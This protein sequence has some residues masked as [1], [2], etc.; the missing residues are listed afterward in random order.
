MLKFIVTGQEAVNFI[1]KGRNDTCIFEHSHQFISVVVQTLRFEFVV[2]VQV[3]NAI[4]QTL[5]VGQPVFV[6][7]FLVGC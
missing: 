3:F 5:Y 6:C 4:L 2:D 7:L 1:G